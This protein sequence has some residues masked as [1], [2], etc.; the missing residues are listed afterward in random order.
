M[1]VRCEKCQTEYE[2]DEARLKPGGVTVKCT[3]C[4]HMFKIRKRSNTSVGAVPAAVSVVAPLPRAPRADSIFDEAPTYQAGGSGA[5]GPAAAASGAANEAPTAVERQW[6]LRLDNG[7]QRSCREL[8]T[9]QQ[10]IVSGV[11]SRESLISRTGKTWKRLADIAELAPY[12]EVAEEARTTRATRITPGQ[13]ASAPAAKPASPHPAVVPRSAGK[14]DL[15]G[16]MLGVGHGPAAQAAG[17][18]IL[19]DDPADAGDELGTTTATFHARPPTAPPPLPPKLS[20]GQKTP[21]MGSIASPRPPVSP[22]ATPPAMPVAVPSTVSGP[23]ARPLTGPVATAATAPATGPLRRPP[24]QPPPPPVKKPGIQAPIDGRTT[25]GW[26]K[27]GPTGARGGPTSGGPRTSEPY[28][29]KLSAARDDQAYGGRVRVTEEAGFETGQVRLLEDDDDELLPGRR[30]SRA[31][32]WL[33]M[34][35][36]AFGGAAAAAVYMFVIRPERAAVATAPTDAADAARAAGSDAAVLAATADGGA[37]LDAADAPVT[38]LDAARGELLANIEPRLRT[39]YDGLAGKEDVPAQVA[40]AQL[41]AGLAQAWIDRAGLVS[42]KPEADKL[43]KDARALALD[44]ATLA[45]RAHKAAPD[46]PGANI[47]MANALRLQGKAAKDIQRYLDA[48]R[49]KPD[50]AWARELALAEALV[51]VRDGKLDQA[52]TQLAVI[53]QGDGALEQSN[54]V[55]AR[56]HRAVVALAQNQRADAKPLVDQ[57]LLAQPEHAGARALAAKLEAA[58]ATSDPLPAEDPRPTPTGANKPT[59]TPTPTAGEKPTP[60]PTPAGGGGESYDKL[61]ARANGL[62][63]S[64]CTRALELY[65]K[66]L[67]QKPNGVEALSGMGYCYVDAKQFASA[68]SK[69]RTALVISSKYEPALW[70]IAEAYQQQGRREQAVESYRRYLEVFPG[71]AKAQRQLDRLGGNDAPAPSPG[72]TPSQPP[73]ESAPTPTPTPPTD[74]APTPAPEAS[75]TGT[76]F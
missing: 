66:A 56:F 52:K 38:P 10:W 36:L 26:A 74:P 72:P 42:D 12:F 71:S 31:G 59:P 70:G 60:A 5:S 45:Q 18:T 46:D 28:V 15:R 1:D 43:R 14:P 8:A 6:L 23:S 65:A 55:R 44:I 11:V 25:G 2:L 20:P 69:F 47:A 67:E 19:P 7:E 4:G 27:D 51:A 13:L 17:G 73:T 75:G 64:N 16:T 3:N 39:A 54:D 57:V 41:G 32:L 40:R 24:T 63:E 76:D 58:V 37:I 30:G 48:A 62:A 33:V 50:P 34:L 29:G 53:D 9:L 61:L 22:P 68:H 21:P 49:A 35:V